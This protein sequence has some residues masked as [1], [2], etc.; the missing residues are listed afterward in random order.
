MWTSHNIVCSI[1]AS[2]ITERLT[3]PNKMYYVV[4]QWVCRNNDITDQP[5]AGAL[6]WQVLLCHR[7]NPN[8]TSLS[9]KN[10]IMTL[11]IRSITLCLAKE[12]GSSIYLFACF[13]NATKSYTRFWQFSHALPSS[14]I[15]LRALSQRD[16]TDFS[17]QMFCIWGTVINPCWSRR[18]CWLWPTQCSKSKFDFVLPN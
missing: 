11:S 7:I 8:E 16:F 12:G 2:I 1:S 4:T 5:G 10:K 6:I 15:L 17:S 14:A 13:F 18:H 9:G 3:T